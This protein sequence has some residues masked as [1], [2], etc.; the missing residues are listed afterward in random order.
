MKKYIN[1]VFFWLW[2]IKNTYVLSNWRFTLGSYGN[3]WVTWNVWPDVYFLNKYGN[4]SMFFTLSFDRVISINIFTCSDK[5]SSWFSC[6]LLI[7]VLL[8]LFF[9]VLLWFCINRA[10]LSVTLELVIT[11]PDLDVSPKILKNWYFFR[12]DGPLL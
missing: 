7:F 8:T 6:I 5:E 12:W 3:A 1:W 4:H 10:E 2:L 9:A 11:T